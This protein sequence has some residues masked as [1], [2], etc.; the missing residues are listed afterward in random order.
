MWQFFSYGMLL[1]V[2]ASLDLSAIAAEEP[3]AG[4]WCAPDDLIRMARS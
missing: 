4:P 1:N 2:V 3:W